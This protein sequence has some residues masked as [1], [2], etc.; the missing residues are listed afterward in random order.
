MNIQ[1][2]IKT[3]SSKLHGL[4]FWIIIIL[5][6]G[7]LAGVSYCETSYSN[8]FNDAVKLGGVIHNGVVYDVKERVTQ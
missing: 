5:I 8:K 1:N 6:C 4:G 7:F 3:V 2:E